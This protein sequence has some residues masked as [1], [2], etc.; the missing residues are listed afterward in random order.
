MPLQ[1]WVGAIQVGCFAALIGLGFQL[2]VRTTGIFMF[3]L[4]GV[5]SFSAMFMSYLAIQE[6]WSTPTAFAAGVL[7]GALLGIACDVI[8]LGPVQRRAGISDQLAIV[9]A[10]IGLLFALQQLSGTLF[11]RTPLQ[12][13]S[14]VSG[15]PYFFHDAVLTRQWVLTVSATA[16]VF[17]VATVLMRFSRYGR[18]M[19]AVGANREAA[20]LLG[21]GERRLRVLAFGA[22]GAIAALGGLFLSTQSGVRFDQGFEW[23]I[24]GFI[25][26][27]IGGNARVVGPLVGGLMVAIVQSYASFK[28][29]ATVK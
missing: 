13:P 20:R 25:A 27:I 8:V 26:C 12:V 7:T 18:Y 22:G 1:V 19:R 6:G 21:I 29:A 2:I 15:T 23:A 10:T 5:A 17:A 9:V 3:P 24:L 28:L 4:G 11:G 14:L 16:G